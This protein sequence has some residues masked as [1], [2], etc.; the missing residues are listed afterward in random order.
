ME[1]DRRRCVYQRSNNSS[2]IEIKHKTNSQ[3][4]NKAIKKIK[5]QI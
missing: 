2:D 5:S 1:M 4:N 3:E